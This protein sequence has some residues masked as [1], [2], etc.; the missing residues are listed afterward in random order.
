MPRN[1]LTKVDNALRIILET[2]NTKNSELIE[3]KN[4][5]NRILASDVVS[6]VNHPSANLSSMDGYAIIIKKN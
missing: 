1:E 5:F 4:S 6:K 2:L 3:T